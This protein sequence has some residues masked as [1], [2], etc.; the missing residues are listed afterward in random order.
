M[1]WV[2]QAAFPAVGISAM[3]ILQ[4]M[5]IADQR[6]LRGQLFLMM[7]LVEVLLFS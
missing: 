3:F 1:A 5:L 2:S 4:T 6:Q 7:K